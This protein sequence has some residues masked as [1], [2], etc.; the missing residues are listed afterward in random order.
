MDIWQSLRAD[1]S[2]RIRILH[3]PAAPTFEPFTNTL[4]FLVSQ[5]YH[6]M[7][8]FYNKANYFRPIHNITEITSVGK[9]SFL[10]KHTNVSQATG[11][12]LHEAR[13]QLVLVDK[14]TRRPVSLPEWFGQRFRQTTMGSKAL[15]MNHFK[16]LT[17]PSTGAVQRVT[18]VQPSHADAYQHTNH[19]AYVKLCHDVGS[20]I[21]K[22][23]KLIHLQ[24]D[25]AF[26]RLK[27]LSCFNQGETNP[28][29]LVDITM[30]ESGERKLSFIAEKDKSEVYQCVMEFYAD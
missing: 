1:E 6:Y 28:G 14:S 12:L 23:G 8:A 10:Y 30:W 15:P 27:N 5:H 7:P 24:D 19:A 17:K 13:S 11:E 2:V 20:L 16:V 29:D 21:A 4:A 22:D 25:L 26:F 18:E 3:D 9:S